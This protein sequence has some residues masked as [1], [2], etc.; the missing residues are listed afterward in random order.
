MNIINKKPFFSI[1]TPTLNSQKSIKRNLNSLYHQDYTNFEHIIIDGGS[2]DQTLDIIIQYSQNALIISKKDFGIADA[3]NQGIHLAQGKIIGIQNSDDYYDPQLFPEIDHIYRHH[4][5]DVIVHGNIRFFDDHKSYIKKPRLL[6]N[7]FFYID[8]PYYHPSI[9]V[10]KKIYQKIGAFN[11][12][13]QFAMDFD[14]LLRAQLRGYSFYYLNRII[15]HFQLQGSAYSH[16][17]KAYREVLS[18][19]ISHGLNP[20]FCKF[21]YLSKLFMNTLKKIVC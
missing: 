3:F 19:Q 6:K 17:L 11:L 21:T 15:S 9:F 4:S 16:P 20:Y 2:S 8:M 13:Y 7:L 1:I 10:P 12:N 18:S 14:F 5:S